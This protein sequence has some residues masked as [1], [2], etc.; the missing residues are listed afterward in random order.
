M[1]IFDKAIGSGDY[2]DAIRA[3]AARGLSAEELFFELAIED[4]RRAG[5]LFLGIHERTDG[6]RVGIA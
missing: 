3:K 4:L 6:R 1:R 5:D 2:D